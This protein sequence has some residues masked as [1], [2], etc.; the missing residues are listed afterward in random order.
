MT[1]QYYPHEQRRRRGFLKAAFAGMAGG[2]LGALSAAP[3]AACAE[4]PSSPKRKA[5][6][7]GGLPPADSGCS[8]GIFAEAGRLVCVSGQGPDD[9]NAPMGTNE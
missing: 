8:Q 4:A 6:V 7:P 1:D 5:L 9:L 2:S 3:D